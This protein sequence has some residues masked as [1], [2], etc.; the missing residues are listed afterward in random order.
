M[1][2]DAT[3]SHG[4]RTVQIRTPGR[5][6]RI[7]VL[8]ICRILQYFPAMHSYSRLPFH[9]LV[10][11]G[12]LAALIP[13]PVPASPFRMEPTRS[14]R[15]Q[16]ADVEREAVAA[17]VTGPD[18]ISFLLT[19]R[20][21][22]GRSAILL[23]TDANGVEQR[24]LDLAAPA[25]GLAAGGSFLAALSAHRD[26]TG[27][28]MIGDSKV[29]TIDL[30]GLTAQATGNGSRL[31]RVL[32]SGDLAVH[33]VEANNIQAGRTIATAKDLKTPEACVTCSPKG[34]V[35]QGAYVAVPLP[36]NRL[37]VIHRSTAVLKVIDLDASAG[38]AASVPL[39]NDELRWGRSMFARQQESAAAVGANA[40]HPTLIVAGAAHPSGDILLLVGPFTP[41]DGA[42]VIRVSPE[43]SLV[44]SLRCG[45][46]N[47]NPNDGPPRYIGL[48]G[49][50]MNLITVRGQVNTYSLSR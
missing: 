4:R 27:V 5:G 16:P 31:I 2:H 21:P 34:V 46:P 49:D 10:V 45:Y 6:A 29:R 3:M 26:S 35:A 43:G 37:A 18:R 32:G 8:T 13:T 25:Y 15:V 22:T 28:L 41:T 1:S 40:A 9:N 44:E 38:P 23:E 17:A 39:D 7:I 14:F 30:V 48:D 33:P 47:F 12:A 50:D 36:A 20:A 42:R 24:R 19:D 11:I